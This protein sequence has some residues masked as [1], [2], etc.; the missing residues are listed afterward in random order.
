MLEIPFNF[1][2]PIIKKQWSILDVHGV[3][4][5]S[6]KIDTK[7][8]KVFISKEQFQDFT[9][10]DKEKL[11]VMI[12]TPWYYIDYMSFK[13]AKKKYIKYY[14]KYKSEVLKNISEIDKIQDT[15]LRWHFLLL[16]ELNL[17]EDNPCERLLY[18]LSI[19]LSELLNKEITLRN[20]QHLYQMLELEWNLIRRRFIYGK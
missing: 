13:Q 16:Y 2:F 17:Y 19:T 12:Y 7:L 9:F 1:K 15:Q 6:N 10:A 11:I 3:Q 8:G 4:F 14:Y 5:S 18:Q 20:T